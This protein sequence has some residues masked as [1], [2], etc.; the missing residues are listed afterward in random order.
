LILQDSLFDIDYLNDFG[1]EK[2]IWKTND[3]FSPG[4]Q[5]SV[6]LSEDL[7][8]LKKIKK[9]WLEQIGQMYGF[10][11]FWNDPKSIPLNLIYPIQ[12]YTSASVNSTWIVNKRGG[13]KH[14]IVT[15]IGNIQTLGL[16]RH[17]Q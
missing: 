14:L 15:R 16:F 6:N 1:W 13:E 12:L 3:E 8:W 2:T 10:L 5:Y 11:E 4:F 7:K 17:S 9:F